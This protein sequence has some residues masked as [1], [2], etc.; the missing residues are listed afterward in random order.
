MS[1]PDTAPHRV[2]HNDWST[3]TVPALGAGRPRLPVSVVI[4][5]Y[6]GQ[7]SLDLTLAALSRQTY[8]AALTEVIVVDDGSRPPLVV[9][10]IRPEN[11]RLVVADGGWGRANALN[12]GARASD[13]DVL[14]WLD[15][16]MVVY[17]E[18]V[19][20]Q[21][22]WHEAIPYA[23]TLGHKRFVDVRP[24]GPG[25]PTAEQV[26]KAAEA[27]T[28]AELFDGV[29]SEPH[30]YVEQI[31]RATDRLRSG[32]HLTFMVHVGATAA[33]R[34]ELYEATGGLDATLRLGEDTEFGYRLA[35]AGA[36]FIPEDE[37][38]AWHLGRTHMMRDAERLRRYNRPYLA[39]RMPQPRWLRR[40]GGSA[41]SV[42]LVTVVLDASGAPLERVRAAVDAILAN[43]ETDLRIHLVGDWAALGEDRTAV[44]TDPA[45]DLRLLAATY[46]SDPR[47]RLVP[48]A[49]ESVFP[50]PFLLTVPPTAGLA[51]S[52]V[53]RLLDVAEAGRAGVVRVVGTVGDPEVTLWRTAALGRARWVRRDGD[54]PLDAVT[55]THG[56]VTV[57]AERIG[58]VDLGRFDAAE[59]AGG[60]GA[61]ADGLVPR[62]RLRPA[63][64][65][66]SGLRSLV[67][68]AALVGWL[69]FAR[70]GARLR[71]LIRAGR[72]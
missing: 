13:G 32:D 26:V 25:W 7:A 33:L 69:S 14:H 45:L 61:A 18:H 59:L 58:V 55:A 6:A 42:P 23:V 10:E 9:P 8:P 43:D 40:V 17:P 4:P 53:R 22:R 31:I 48:H 24:D 70:A 51:R 27:G 28:V 65:E 56:A 29:A 38:R 36:V 3:V 15:A 16:D 2:A 41:W 12:I 52:A 46:R 39:D 54:S 35:Q 21:A 1:R 50:S 64:V 68:A 30:G 60:I 72:R 19:E 63:S 34:R 37:A 71:R 66:V 47:V 5:A 62:G 49:P 11:C 67:R 44:L 57:A 20:A